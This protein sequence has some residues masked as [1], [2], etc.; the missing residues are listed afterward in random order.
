M[1]DTDSGN[2]DDPLK[3]L[4][5]I[6]SRRKRLATLGADPLQYTVIP[7]KVRMQILHALDNAIKLDQKSVSEPIDLTF[8]FLAKFFREELGVAKLYGTHDVIEEFRN[9]FLSVEDIDQTVDAIE[10]ICWVIKF[11]G[12]RSEYQRQT[13]ALLSI[14]R[15][16]NGRLMEAGIGF[17]YENGAIIES[18]SRYLHAEVVVPAMHLLSSAKYEAANSEFMA[19][20]KAFRDGDSEQCLVECCKAFESVI[21]VIGAERK[22]ELASDATAKTLVKA[23]FEHDLIPSYLES[24]FTGIRTVLE[25]GVG[26]LR[27][28]S[29]GHGAGTKVRVVPRSLAAFQLHQTAAA[30]TLLAEAHAET[31]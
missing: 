31:V 15:V 6:Y 9:W 13:P 21:K 23:V 11:M 19:A 24:E 22:W 27:N 16:I 29:G 25:S 4:P 20:H 8:K 30:I 18:N 5:D 7:H 17:Q 3:E 14:I 1:S 26:T 2:G 28:K 12:E 10:L